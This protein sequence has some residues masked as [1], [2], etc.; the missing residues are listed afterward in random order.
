VD[1]VP[2]VLVMAYALPGHLGAF[3]RD[4]ESHWAV[5]FELMRWLPTTDMG[6]VEPFGFTDGISQPEIDWAR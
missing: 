4:L 3:G 1:A 6:G 5:P 2:H